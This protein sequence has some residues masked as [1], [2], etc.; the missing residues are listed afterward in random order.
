MRSI[1]AA[2]SRETLLRGPFG[3]A[4]HASR[5]AQML[6]DDTGVVVAANVAAGMLAQTDADRLV[7]R[8]LDAVLVEDTQ[9]AMPIAMAK[10]ADQ[11]SEVMCRIGVGRFSRPVACAVTPDI[12]EGLHLVAL[13]HADD[14]DAD[15]RAHLLAAAVDSSH[16]AVFTVDAD[17][18]ITAGSARAAEAVGYTPR[19]LQGRPV[20]ELVVEGCRAEFTRLVEAAASGHDVFQHDTKVVDH[21]GAVLEVTVN[22]APLRLRPG[23][24]IVGVSVIVQDITAR[25]MLERRL[26]DHAE[27]DPLTEIYNRRRL[28]RELYRAV[29]LAQRHSQHDGALLLFDVD[30]FKRVN[31]TLGHA[32]GDDVLRTLARVVGRCLRDT[33]VLAR[34]GG[35]EFAVVIGDADAAAAQAVAA[36]V[37]QATRECLSPWKVTVSLGVAHFTGAGEEAPDRIMAAADRAMYRAKAAGGDAVSGA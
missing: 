9:A 18:A 29:R 17:G 33:D 30:D 34:L 36:K 24:N 25:K 4:F 10:P 8:R 19:W 23:G 26:R 6:V 2:D 28:E 32:A 37:L 35:D 11:G 12:D 16:D 20:A 5:E 31:D 13:Q 1:N 3:R 15:A 22:M 7:G 21:G 27:R 14:A